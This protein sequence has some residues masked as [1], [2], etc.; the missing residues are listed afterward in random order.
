MQA[1]APRDGDSCA[2]IARDLHP[3][4]PLD[5]LCCPATHKPLRVEGDHLVADETHRYRID[6]SGIPLFAETDLSPEAERQRAHYQKIAASYVENMQYPHTEEYHAYLDR[7]FLDAFAGL[8]LE[9]VVEVCCGH[10]DVARLLGARVQRGVGVD[11]ST[12]MLKA[13]LK[14]GSPFTFVQGDATALPLRDGAFACVVLSGGIHHVSDRRRLFGEVARVLRPGGAL[15][16]R[17]P[18]NDFALWRWLRA[19]IYRAAPGLDA[20][21]ESPLEHAETAAH[22]TEAGLRLELWRPCGFLGFCLLMNSDVLVVNRLLRFL[23]GIRAL[24][25]GAA[26]FDD[27]VTSRLASVGLQVVGIARKPAG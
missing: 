27:W 21:T 12:P 1:A 24:T 10:G 22:L 3:M 13:A 11:I 23:P 16:F 9:T 18:L 2:I 7:V 4:L 17:E 15:V 20:E 6:A 26:R 25:R 8:A 5:L 14:S 19:V